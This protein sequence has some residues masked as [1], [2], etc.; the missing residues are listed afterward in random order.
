[1]H[2]EL[3][4]GD[5]IA[6]QSF[7]VP[8]NLS[9]ESTPWQAAENCCRL[10]LSARCRVLGPKVALGKGFKVRGGWLSRTI[11]SET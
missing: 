3:R 1:M 5:Y 6:N 9:T 10:Y 11:Q 4:Y 7:T 2:V 8:F